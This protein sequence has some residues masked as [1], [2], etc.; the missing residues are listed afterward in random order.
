MAPLVKIA[1]GI[2][3]KMANV[4]ITYITTY[5]PTNLL[6]HTYLPTHLFTYLPTTTY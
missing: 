5:P 1:N 2:L 4:I 3:L 6:Q